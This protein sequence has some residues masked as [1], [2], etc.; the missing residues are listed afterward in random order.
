[1]Y[2]NESSE[3]WLL[4][5]SLQFNIWLVGW[6]LLNIHL[7]YL[8]FICACVGW[9]DD[10]DELLIIID[11]QITLS[12]LNVAPKIKSTC[13]FLFDCYLFSVTGL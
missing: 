1:M 8:S 2:L 13:I 3:T 4:L 11:F 12:N 5:Q 10:K 7:V 9:K 6:M